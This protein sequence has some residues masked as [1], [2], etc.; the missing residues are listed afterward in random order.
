MVKYYPPKNGTQRSRRFWYRW[1]NPCDRYVRRALIEDSSE[2]KKEQAIL[3]SG[4]LAE[5]NP[6]LAKEWH[7]L[8][9]GEQ[10]P[11]MITSGS[12]QKAWWLCRKCGHEWKA[13]VG[14][15]HRGAGCPVCAREK[16]KKSK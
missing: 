4:T 12:D 5:K 14:S 10:T 6:N 8:K 2:K 16:R 7:P 13:S 15:R 3:R 9:N 1:G 11:E